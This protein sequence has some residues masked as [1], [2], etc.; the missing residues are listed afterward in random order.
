ML[1]KVSVVGVPE[2]SLYMDFQASGPLPYRA[3]IDYF[4][5]TEYVGE[6]FGVYH[7]NETK[8]ILEDTDQECIISATGYATF[9]LDHCSYYVL[10]S[11]T[12]HADVKEGRPYVPIL[13]MII[14]VITVVGAIML[15]K[16]GSV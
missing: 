14:T 3:V 1:S 6:R 2:K 15:Y 8:G 11:E 16:K 5:G 7:Y 4:V 10:V 13:I 9:F 12:V